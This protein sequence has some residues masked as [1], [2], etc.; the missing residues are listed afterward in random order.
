VGRPAIAKEGTASVAIRQQSEILLFSGL[1]IRLDA[2]AIS[3]K[4]EFCCVDC[5]GENNSGT[6]I[7]LVKRAII[8]AKVPQAQI[9][10]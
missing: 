3:E 2:A 4:H 8:S 6:A 9:N 7:E 1:T 5:R 10:W